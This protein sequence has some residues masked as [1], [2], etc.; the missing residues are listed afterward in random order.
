MAR[1]GPLQK[2]R[3]TGNARLSPVFSP[4]TIGPLTLPDR[5]TTGRVHVIGGAAKAA[6]PDAK[7]AI[8]QA[9][10]RVLTP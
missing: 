9:V 2:D 1:P 5:V 8:D 4:L 7:R 6:E 10:R 3:V